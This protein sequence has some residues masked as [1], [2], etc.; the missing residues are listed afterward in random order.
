M[1][2][3]TGPATWCGGVADGNLEFVGRVDFQVKIRGYRIELGEV[4]SALLRHPGVREAVVEA[5][6]DTPGKKRLVAYV[7]T[8]A[9]IR[10]DRAASLVAVGIARL[11]GAVGVS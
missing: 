5:R 6:E 2:G 7:V 4:E 1:H 10:G 9:W 8:G 3:C 11:H